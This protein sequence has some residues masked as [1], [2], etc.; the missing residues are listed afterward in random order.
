MPRRQVLVQLD[1]D[2]VTELDRIALKSGLNRSE[3]IRRGAIAVISAEQ[4][5]VDDELLQ[6]SY[7]AIPQDPAIVEAAMKLAGEN[8]PPW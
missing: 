6:L 3:L 8:L 4:S 7:R 1:D 5:R 2:L